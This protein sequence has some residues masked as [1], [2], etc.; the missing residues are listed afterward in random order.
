[1]HAPKH[2]HEEIGAGYRDLI[3]A[4][5]AR[6]VV[7]RRQAFL[8]KWCLRCRAVADNL[9]EAGERLFTFTRLAPTQWKAA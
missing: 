4:E 6:E 1:M 2:L 5:T 7:K 8:R 9:D 3:S